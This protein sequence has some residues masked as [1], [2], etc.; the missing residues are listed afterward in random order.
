MNT[1]LS[2]DVS[3]SAKQRLVYLWRN[4]L[5]NLPRPGHGLR[6]VPWNLPNDA[7]DEW[8]SGKAS[9]L[10]VLSE[11][12]LVLHLPTFLQ[13][14]KIQ[15]LDIG[16]GSGRSCNLLSQAALS[17]D[18]IG[19]DLEDR[20]K[21]TNEGRDGFTSSFIQGD[22]HDAMPQTSFDIILS[23]SAL[24][25]IPDD[26][27][28]ATQFN[29]LLTE[30]GFQVHIVPAPGALYGYLWH[31]FRQYS[32]NAIAERFEGNGI[33]IYRLG[34][35][36]SFLAHVLMITIP[37]ILFRFSL[38]NMFPSFYA[39]ILR[40]SLHLDPAIPFPAISYAIICPKTKAP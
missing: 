30:N 2:G 13:G 37:E 20:F 9:P 12:F 35:L 16:C 25:H 11:A 23:N 31:G 39:S 32:L 8:A 15:V 17:G 28:L 27:R 33:K 14:R 22:V 10:R 34:G 18:Y 4:T 1:E 36:F 6:S 24:E 5:K 7:F 29:E 21:H 38:R 3:L 19:L 26:I 40:I